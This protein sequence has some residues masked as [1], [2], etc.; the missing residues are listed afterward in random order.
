MTKQQMFELVSR[1]AHLTKKAARE[2]VE[3]SWRKSKKPLAKVKKSCY[4]D[5]GLSKLPMSRISRSSFPAP[6]NE[7]LSKATVSPALQPERPSEKRL[8][9]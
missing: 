6:K 2:A 4:Q 7:K 5:S 8:N 9:K 1:K 3:L